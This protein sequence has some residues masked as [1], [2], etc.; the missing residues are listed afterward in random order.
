MDYTQA[1]RIADIVKG[2][3]EC[4]WKLEL[5]GSRRQGSSVFGQITSECTAYQGKSLTLDGYDVLAL[6][7]HY[8]DRVNKLKAKLYSIQII[9]KDV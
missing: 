3:E 1:K 6:R 7:A 5:L 8:E 4:E 9:E 2:I